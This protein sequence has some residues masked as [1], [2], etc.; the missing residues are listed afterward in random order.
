MDL[1]GRIR[2]SAL[3]GAQPDPLRPNHL[4]GSETLRFEVD[5]DGLGK[6]ED[7]GQLAWAARH[8]DVTVLG[9][10]VALGSGVVSIPGFEVIGREPVPGQP[11]RTLVRVRPSPEYRKKLALKLGEHPEER[12]R[13]K[14]TESATECSKREQVR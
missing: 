11:G 7:G 13:A 9:E 14:P 5:A 2:P 6:L 10:T 4:G 1:G 8:L 3:R 12:P